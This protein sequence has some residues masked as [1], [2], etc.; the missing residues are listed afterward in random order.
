[1]HKSVIAADLIRSEGE[2]NAQNDEKHHNKHRV[3]NNVVCDDV[4]RFKFRRRNPS[5][6]TLNI[7]ELN[8]TRFKIPRTSRCR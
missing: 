5:P 4:R 2:D 8:A 6:Q 7:R 1:M 3:A